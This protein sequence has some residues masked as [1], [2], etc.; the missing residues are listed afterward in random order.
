VILEILGSRDPHVFDVRGTCYK[1]CVRRAYENGCSSRRPFASFDPADFLFFLCN[2]HYIRVMV[3][4]LAALLLVFGLL[5]LF[6]LNVTSTSV[7]FLFV[8]AITLA[9]AAISSGI[10]YQRFRNRFTGNVAATAWMAAG[11]NL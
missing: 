2:A 8:V 1:E 3:M 5:P 6:F 10:Q 7:W 9:W 11:G 4:A